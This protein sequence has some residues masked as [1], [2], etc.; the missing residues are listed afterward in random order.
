MTC[1]EGLRFQKIIHIILINNIKAGGDMVF[2]RFLP[3]CQ[4]VVEI[5]NGIMPLSE[6]VLPDGRVY[7]AIPDGLNILSWSEQTT[8]AFFACFNDSLAAPS[9]AS[10]TKIPS[11]SLFWPGIFTCV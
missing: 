5:N 8:L 3:G 9:A 10:A 2:G 4:V 7:D 6:G 11:T 1:P